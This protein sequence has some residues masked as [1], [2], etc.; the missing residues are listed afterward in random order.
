MASPTGH[1]CSGRIAPSASDHT[2]TA[3]IHHGASCEVAGTDEAAA[4]DHVAGADAPDRHGRAA[5]QH[6]DGAV[7][8]EE[9][10]QLR[11]P[12]VG[13]TSPGVVGGRLHLVA[14]VLTVMSAL[15]AA[16]SVE[17]CESP[18]RPRRGT[19]GGRGAPHDHR[20]EDTLTPS[21][22]S[23]SASSRVAA[24]LAVVEPGPPSL[25]AGPALNCTSTA[26]QV[27]R[28]DA[29]GAAARRAGASRAPTAVA[30]AP[31]RP[32]RRP[33]ARRSPRPR[34]PAS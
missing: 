30:R 22:A 12:S 17:R 27:S 4:A 5:A 28:P 24:L 26:A 34:G 25:A 15:C 31:G 11:Q 32:P 23:P 10:R 1:G 3:G 20:R 13:R 14:L 18:S 9:G 2:T 6:R 29:L 7:A 33:R 21:S 8:V 19:R 16:R